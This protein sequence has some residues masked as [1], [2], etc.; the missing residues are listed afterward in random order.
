MKISKPFMALVLGSAILFSCNHNPSDEV[1]K[2]EVD[3]ALSSG[4][5][6]AGITT[7]VKEGVVTITGSFANDSLKT[8]AGQAIK[9]IE[10]IKDVV[11]SSTVLTPPPVVDPLTQ[12]LADATKDFPGVTAVSSN[13]VVTL[14]GTIK[15][16]A[17]P[18]LMKAISALKPGKI[19]NH[20]TI[21]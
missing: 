9:A 13:G 19:D 12:S 16:D 11:D 18:K 2:T 17:L 20:L 7:T 3:K 1:L 21:K 10:G 4:S 8:A 6:L 14:T 5:D 15:K